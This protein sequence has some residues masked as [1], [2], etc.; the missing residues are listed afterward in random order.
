MNTT[1]PYWNS[2]A[3]DSRKSHKV[4]AGTLGFTTEIP[5]PLPVTVGSTYFGD[6]ALPDRRTVCTKPWGE[7]FA[8]NDKI[9]STGG[10]T[11]HQH[12]RETFSIF[13]RPI[14]LSCVKKKLY[15]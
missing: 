10:G 7:Y 1:S 9:P 4:I 5:W 11:P 3:F 2:F 14:L 6:G 15:T 12:A 8:V 13:A